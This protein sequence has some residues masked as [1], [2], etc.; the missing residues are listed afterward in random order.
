MSEQVAR[1]TTPSRFQLA[2]MRRGM[3]GWQVADAA[4]ITRRRWS[5][6]ERG[7]TSASESEVAKVAEIL[8]FPAGFFYRPHCE[9]PTAEQCS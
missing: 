1:L 2:R 5:D 7:L 3:K 9:I 4:C 8:R 6:I